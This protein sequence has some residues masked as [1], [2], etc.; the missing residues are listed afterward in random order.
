[1]NTRCRSRI[2]DVVLAAALVVGATAIGLEWSAKATTAEPPPL[3]VPPTTETTLAPPTTATTAAPPTTVTTVAT[4][5]EADKEDT[6]TL[7]RGDSGAAVADVQRRLAELR[8]DPGA[9]DGNFGEATEYAVLAFE[10]V[11]GLEPTGTVTEAV[12]AALAH[13]STPPP[14]RPSGGDDRVEVDLAT[15]LLY[16]Y[17]QG[18]LS[19]ISH[20]STGSGKVFCEAG[21]CRRAIT[22]TGTF[23]FLWRAQGWDVGPLGGLYNPV[24]FTEDGIA[25]HGALSVPLAPASHGCVRIPM[26]TAERFPSLVSDGDP[27]YVVDGE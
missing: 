23:R 18:R 27:V 21:P 25:V 12:R 22:P 26:H 14:L 8:Y 17:R 24:Y 2:T 4:D 19:L 5:D 10:K 3:T 16:V 6:S 11:Q 20:V 13:P 7:A 9:A 1:M 15:Q